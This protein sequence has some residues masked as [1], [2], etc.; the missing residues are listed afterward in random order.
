M[1]RPTNTTTKINNRPAEADELDFEDD[2][3]TPGFGEELELQDYDPGAGEAGLTEASHP[4]EG[5]T[6]DDLDPEILIHEDG[7]RSEYEEQQ[8]NLDPTDKTLSIVSGD[9]I[10]AGGGLDEAELARVDPLDKN[11]STDKNT[12]KAG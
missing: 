4:G 6:D 1:N 10:G 2:L 11:K 9:E 3:P 12:K 5:P 8:G 7:A